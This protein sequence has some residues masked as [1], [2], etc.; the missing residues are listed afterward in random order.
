[1]KGFTLIEILLVVALFGILAGL[2]IPFYQSYQQRNDVSVAA[3]TVVQ[4]ARRAQQLARAV[5]GDARWGLHIASG[6]ITIFQ[7][8]TYAGRDQTEDEVISISSAVGVSG[9]TDILFEKVTGYVT[10]T[11]SSTLSATNGGSKTITVNAFGTVAY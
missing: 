8:D 11:T 1:M 9:D 2:S 6:A 3:D 7:G 5:D 4:S 10:D